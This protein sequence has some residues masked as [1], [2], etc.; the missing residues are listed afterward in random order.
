[1]N[2]VFARLWRPAVAMTVLAATGVVT[3]V[4]SAPP[5]AA[6]ARSAVV[7]GGS[8]FAQPIY[9]QWRADVAK[10]PYL[11][12]VDYQAAGSTFGRLKYLTGE[13][14]F[15]G[16]DIPF[17]ISEQRQ[18]D[19]S[20]RNQYAYVPTTAGGLG[21]MYNVR[22]AS[23]NR[24]N[25]LQLKPAEV[26]RLFTEETIYWDDPAIV[27]ENPGVAFQH[28]LAR[29]VVR[30]DGSGTSYVLSE[31]CIATSPD[32]WA[33]F[34]SMILSRFN[35][36]ATP[37]FQQGKPTSQW[38]QGFGSVSQA[39]A[40]DGVA[41]VVASDVS[42]QDSIAYDEAE[43]AVQRGFPNASVMNASGVYT[44]PTPSNVT[45]A[46]AFAKGRSDG[47]FALS[48]NG[49]DPKAYFPSSYSYMVVPT[50]NFDPAKGFTLASFLNYCVTAGQRKSEQLNFAR[51]SDVLVNLA[52]DQIARIP[53]APPRPTDLAGASATGRP[54]GQV[55]TVG[56]SAPAGA[57][58]QGKG[59]ATGPAT[60]G[61]TRSV[62]TAAAGGA[63]DAAGGP[64]VAGA[65]GAGPGSDGAST[66]G[67]G[68]P[69]G[70]YQIDVKNLPTAPVSAVQNPTD[71]ISNKDTLWYFALGFALVGLGLALGAGSNASL[72][73][74]RR[75][76]S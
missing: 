72:V 67:A 68:Q 41:N 75:E 61:S 40:S 29:A 34:I 15:G 62:G 53:G 3:P 16:S 76:T 65:G 22:D 74:G 11:L 73:R 27:A 24:V 64:A 28:K 66:A 52:L 17:Q 49:N 13:L 59:A 10:P 5:V 21:F 30:S 56:A 63:A 51:L 18:I 20:S 7:G 47:T 25:N 32:V 50:A 57:A 60:S 44:Q 43:F 46:L 48:Y 37:E 58:N 14:D 54:Q 8:S 33:R 26:C 23:G 39:Y 6:Q 45:A 71:L 1:M 35:D 38:P 4:A 69:E 9:S 70:G 42:G 19:S 36:Q 12:N 2:R 31:F 55:P